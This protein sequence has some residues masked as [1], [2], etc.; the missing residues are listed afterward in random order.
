MAETRNTVSQDRDVSRRLVTCTLEE[1]GFPDGLLDSIATELSRSASNTERFLMRFHHRQ[2]PESSGTASRP[3]ISALTISLGY[4]LGGLTPLAPYFV[5]HTNQMAFLWSVA[6]MGVALFLF[7][8]IK[9]WLVGEAKKSVC[10][11]GGV[12]M[13]CLGGVAAA[14]AMGCVKAIGT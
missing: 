13:V 11:K 10:F 5:F 1:Y 9:T 7:G 6:V 8:Y 12:Q 4:F 3:Y 2:L 14:A